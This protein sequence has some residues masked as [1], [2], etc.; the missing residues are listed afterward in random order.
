M[1]L[2]INSTKCLKNSHQRFEEEILANSFYE[3]CITLMPKQRHHKK[4]I[5][6]YFLRVQMQKSSKKICKKKKNL[7]TQKK[8]LILGL[9][10]IPAMGG[11]VGLTHE[12]LSMQ[13]IYTILISYKNNMIILCRKSFDKIQ[14]P[15]LIKALKLGIQLNF[16]NLTKTIYQHS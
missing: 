8:N 6:Q 5:E 16:L 4:I 3:A 9:K 15:F 11:E 10:F 2:L 12:N 14:L 13:Y 1:V 7:A